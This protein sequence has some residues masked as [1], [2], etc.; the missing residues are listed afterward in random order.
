MRTIYQNNGFRIVEIADQSWN[1]ADLK[2]DCYN[3]KVNPDISFEKLKAEERDFERLVFEEGV[4]GYVLQEWNPE[5]G[6]DLMTKGWEETNNS[7]WGFVGQFDENSEPP[8]IIDRNHY[9][10][11]ELQKIAE[12]EG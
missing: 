10:V 8:H 4:Y 3:P 2:G 7:C 1:M 12:K 6:N 11:H 9:F 5:I